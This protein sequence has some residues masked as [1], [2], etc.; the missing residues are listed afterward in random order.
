MKK[1]ILIIIMTICLLCILFLFTGCTSTRITEGVVIDKEHTPAHT[2]TYIMNSGKSV[3]P[4][5]VFHSESYKILIENTVNNEVKTTW[6]KISSEEYDKI[7]IGD[8][9]QGE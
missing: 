4:Y 9:Y 3:Y 5:T 7:N 1:I 2:K 6:I 8:Y